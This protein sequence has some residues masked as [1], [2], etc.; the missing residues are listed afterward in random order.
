[1]VEKKTEKTD[2]YSVKKQKEL[3]KNYPIRII[4]IIYD[5]IYLKSNDKRSM[6]L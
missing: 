4:S 1:M 5:N 3:E 2:Y 6:D